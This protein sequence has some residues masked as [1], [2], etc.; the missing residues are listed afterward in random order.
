[1]SAPDEPELDVTSEAEL[2][3]EKPEGD[4]LDQHRDVEAPPVE[5]EKDVAVPVEAPEAD[6]VEQHR[7][8]RTATEDDQAEPS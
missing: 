8:V 1:M 5:L 6:T 7:V 3:A 4:T 2:G